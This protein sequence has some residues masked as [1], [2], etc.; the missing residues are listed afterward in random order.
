M[1]VIKS[2]FVLLL[3]A[4][5]LTVFG[6]AKRPF[7]G[8]IYNQ[9]YQ[10]YIKMNFYENNIEVPEQEIFGS[11]PGY[12]GAK[13][14]TRKWLITEASLT[15]QRTARL[16]IINDYGSEDLT[17]TLTSNSDGTYTLTQ[18]EGSAIKIVVDRKWVK[19]PKRLVFTMNQSDK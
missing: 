5:P 14:D 2:L 9:T 13:R 4:L 3:V 16:S 10:V 8:T 15:D 12:F 18:Q 11:L 1:K 7:S 17:A 19:L 6:Q